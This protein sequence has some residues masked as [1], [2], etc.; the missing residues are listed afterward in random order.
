MKSLNF[1]MKILYTI[2]S[3]KMNIYKLVNNHNNI[4]K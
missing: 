4:K 2:L 1:I 3:G